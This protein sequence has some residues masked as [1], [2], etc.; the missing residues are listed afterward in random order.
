MVYR[1]YK[2]TCWKVKSLICKWLQGVLLLTVGNTNCAVK[3]QQQSV[4]KNFELICLGSAFFFS[5]P[6]QSQP[7]SYRFSLFLV[8]W[9]FFSLIISLHSL[10][11]TFKSLLQ[12]HLFVED[13]MVLRREMETCTPICMPW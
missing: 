3:V 10:G 4:Q 12:K 13:E 9:S 11:Q 8:C 6:S 1:A 2:N 7:L 5:I